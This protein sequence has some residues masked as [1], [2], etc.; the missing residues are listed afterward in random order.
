MPEAGKIVDMSAEKK[1]RQIPDETANMPT[2]RETLLHFVGLII[3]A[4][5]AKAKA[6]QPHKDKI[7]SIKRAAKD[8]G[9]FMEELKMVISLMTAELDETPEVKTRRIVK[10]LGDAG[11]LSREISGQLEMFS[12]FA[13]PASAPASAKL[14]EQGYQLGL[15]GKNLPHEEGTDAW[16]S[17]MVGWNRGQDILK[18]DFKNSMKP[19]V[20]E[21]P[22]A[23]PVKKQSAAAEKIQ[24]Q[25]DENKAKK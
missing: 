14:E 2:D 9:L 24:K 7:K 20:A 23:K 4:E 16:R 5:E 10:Y 11:L 8:H 18:R 15:L 6:L 22:K 12:S 19:K 25:A 3:A 1:A 21:K 13:L 17:A